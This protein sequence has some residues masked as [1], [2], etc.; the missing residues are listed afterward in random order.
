LTT[1]LFDQKRGF[2][3]TFLKLHINTQDNIYNSLR[4]LVMDVYGD[5]IK[6]IW[7]KLKFSFT[8]CFKTENSACH[9][10]AEQVI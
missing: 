6:L 5:V 9:W 3:P 2:K 1:F 10:Q 4:T 7:I 8:F